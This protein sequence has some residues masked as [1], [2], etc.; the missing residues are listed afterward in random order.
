MNR[1]WRLCSTSAIALALVTVP[2]A[3]QA[4]SDSSS[5]IAVRGSER[6]GFTRVVFEGKDKA[7]QVSVNQT[8]KSLTLDFSK[9]ST[10]NV[11]GADPSS[12][13]RVSGYSQTS[14]GRVK[15][16]F[17]ASADVRHFVIG[18]RLIV[19]I[20]DNAASP[21]AKATTPV[22]DITPSSGTGSGKEVTPPRKLT[23]AIEAVAPEKTPDKTKTA[24]TKTPEAKTPD[25]K[26][27][28]AKL[29]E[30]K[31][32]D[33][34]SVERKTEDKQVEE[35][36]KKLGSGDGHIKV[37]VEPP[38]DGAGSDTG[39]A[40]P[41]EPALP[42]HQI[43]LAGTSAF[44]VAA[45]EKGNKLWIVIDKPDFVV[46]PQVEGPNQASF[47]S[48]E[49]IPQKDVTIFRTDWPA[50]YKLSGDGGGL[51]WKIALNQKEPR[52][53]Q[54]LLVPKFSGPDDKIVTPSLVFKSIS[55]HRAATFDDPDTGD[56]MIVGLVDA[57]QDY[58]GSEQNYAELESYP[59]IFGFAIAPKTDDIIVTKTADGAEITKK[60]SG[61][62]LSPEKD[63]LPYRKSTEPT[64]EA[65]SKPSTE[66]SRIFDFGNWRIGDKDSFENS[67]RLM[68]AGL[69]EQT[70][71]KKAETLIVL[72]KL[73][74]SHGYA[75]EAYGFFDLANQ[76]VPDMR[77]NPEMLAMTGAV[78]A[79]MGHSQDAFYN[80][81]NPVLNNVEEIKYWRAYTL[82]GL[83]DW[84]QAAKNLPNDVSVLATYPDEVL[85]P[86]GLKLAEVALREGNRPKAK[87]IL[88]IIEKTK[89]HH[90]PLPYAS[91]LD[92]L[93][94]EYA[95]Q[96]GEIENARLLWEPLEKGKDDLYRAKS[97]LAM[98]MLR[99]G[100]KEIT[101]DK[102]IDS[103]EG[104]RYAWRGDELETAVNY[105]LGKLYL[106]KG[107]PVRAMGL[108]RQ[109][110]NLIPNS[111]Q[112]KAISQSM[113]STF[114]GLY[115][116]DKIQKLTPLQALTLYDEFSEL[117][118][119]GPEGD[120]LARQLAE[121]LVDV[122]LL[123]RAI[124]LLKQQVD[125]RLSGLEGSNVA[126]RLA[127]LQVQDTK[128]NEALET[129]DK[130]EKFLEGVPS[131]VSDPKRRAI[132]M[133]RARAYALNGKTKEAAEQ[134]SLLPQDED[135]L[136]LRADIS[137]KAKKWQDAAD[138]LEQVI[139]LENISLTRP[140][141]DAQAKTI[142]DWAVALYL[143]DNR[144]VL[145][146]LRERYS[147]LMKLTPKAKEFEVVTRPRQNVLLAD[148]T[149]I[150]NIIGETDIFG[151]FLQSFKDDQKEQLKGPL[152]PQ[153]SGRAAVPS[154][155]GTPS[156]ANVP[157]QLK[158]N[159]SIK[160][161][162]VL[163]D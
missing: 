159:P 12:L 86:V 132:A 149:T 161:D 99:Y 101:I 41:A 130:A 9:T 90:M 143:A 1:F 73:M 116:S 5:A 29:A 15:I 3:G 119:Q 27:A 77:S 153:S 78:Q 87:A 49:R 33:T 97:R 64:P 28:D 55:F 31:T 2:L 38:E 157:E 32:S 24:E 107:D 56:P 53:P 100:R 14:T 25:V 71:Q 118:P 42:D 141:T 142:L 94:G 95:R 13:P 54:H 156:T 138:A 125:T 16:D 146:N 111:E 89:N 58:T 44:A 133:L 22:Q 18:N 124:N 21:K 126:I 88:D 10:F 79:L 131:E 134:L 36:T 11:S 26:P 19:D 145:A 139:A 23:S 152:P 154:A 83:D 72:G 151:N 137:W 127:S 158:S 112:G 30:T 148:R 63:I 52:Y 150:E 17:A 75:P 37:D 105:N 140:L 110:A 51:I 162:E 61:L 120:R 74:M 106:D 104:L 20:K 70:D 68:M 109:A 81:S 69:P 121:R 39:K 67:S 47:K 82:A 129:L 48:F 155:T 117:V 76:Y 147:D 122:D 6:D 40:A 144:Y 163:A 45:F 102:A 160:A 57:A 59:A 96:K 60:P 91:A 136:R 62:A 66:V 135:V 103:L 92:Y 34:K 80:F 113:H 85:W 65:D 128:P 50:G 84:Q 4:A 115:S 46:P 108:M 7:P 43:N 93:K 35:L 114:E 8:D 98:T 123:P